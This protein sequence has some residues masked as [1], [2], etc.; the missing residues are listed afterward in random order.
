MRTCWILKDSLELKKYIKKQYVYTSEI[1][2]C[3]YLLYLLFTTVSF[4]FVLNYIIFIFIKSL[5]LI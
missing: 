5:V 4:L 1:I 3:F 2:I